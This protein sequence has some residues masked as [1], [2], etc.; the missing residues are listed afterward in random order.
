MTVCHA[1]RSSDK[2]SPT[3]TFIKPVFI[4]VGEGM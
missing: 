3:S 4:E 1:D 2:A